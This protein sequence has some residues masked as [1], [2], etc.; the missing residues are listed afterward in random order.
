[1]PI[2]AAAAHDRKVGLAVRLRT[3]TAPSN[4]GGLVER[5][6]H[7]S[8]RPFVSC[9]HAFASISVT[10]VGAVAIVSSSTSRSRRRRR[11]NQPPASTSGGCDADGPSIFNFG[12]QRRAERDIACSSLVKQ[13]AVDASIS[14][15][16]AVRCMRRFF[17]AACSSSSSAPPA[18]EEGS[19]WWSRA[20]STRPLDQRRMTPAR[21]RLPQSVASGIADP[22]VCDH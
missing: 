10:S 2:A 12:R 20:P 21:I 8:W 16:V 19:S 1:V 4:C 22:A 14:S 7:R 15:R 17:D 18:M 3:G 11:C 13:C 6:R 5:R 9:Q